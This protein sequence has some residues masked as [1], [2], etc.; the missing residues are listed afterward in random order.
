MFPDRGN[1]A[2][3]TGTLVFGMI[4]GQCVE[5]IRF[6]NGLSVQL[7]RLFLRTDR[8]GSHFDTGSV[9]GLKRFP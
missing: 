7:I 6:G 2:V 1:Q 3:H 8:D 5:V 4:L 9:L